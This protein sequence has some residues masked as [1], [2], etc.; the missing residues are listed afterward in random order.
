M[1]ISE[2]KSP[3]LEKYNRLTGMLFTGVF[4]EQIVKD[5]PELSSGNLASELSIYCRQYP[6]LSLSDH[7]SCFSKLNADV[8]KF[9]PTIE[10]LLRLALTPPASSCVA[11]RSFS[12]LRRLKTWL[13]ASMTQQRLNSVAVCHIH[14]ELL[15]G[16]SDKLIAEMF[17]SCCD[18]RRRIF[19]S[20]K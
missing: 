15:E 17:V 18:E 19:G 2:V 1:K 10:I 7:H 5:Y 16:I 14:R 11:E 4:D 12:A 20:F 3:D 13:R 9:F 6:N 8:K